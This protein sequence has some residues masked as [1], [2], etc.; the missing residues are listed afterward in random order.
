M[1]DRFF[2][3]LMGMR[4]GVLRRL[5]SMPDLVC[6]EAKAGDPRGVLTRTLLARVLVGGL[7]LDL[8]GPTPRLDMVRGLAAVDTM[9]RRALTGMSERRR[10]LAGLPPREEDCAR[11]FWTTFL[12]ILPSSR[13][14]DL[15]PVPPP[16]FRM[17]WF[18]PT[19]LTT[20]PDREETGRRVVLEL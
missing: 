18:L 14:E 20:L 6:D 9:F 15:G 10:A 4:A 19:V 17:D 8:M 13:A 3:C 11:I 7:C 1:G 2:F 5:V 12:P 16:I